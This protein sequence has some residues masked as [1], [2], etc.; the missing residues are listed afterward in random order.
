M[1]SKLL[2]LGGGGHCKSVIDTIM[3]LDAYCDIGIIDIKNHLNETVSGINIIGTDDDIPSLHNKGYTHAFITLGSIGNPQ[4]RIE[5]FNIIKEAGFE[6][7]V[8]IDK[9][10]NVSKTAIVNEGVFIGKNAIINAEAVIKKGAIINSGAIIEHD[11]TIS[12]FVHIAPGAVLGGDVIIGQN[13][14]IGTNTTIKQQVRIGR[15]CIIGMGSVVCKDIKDCILAYGNP[16]RE[17]RK[18]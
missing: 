2:L 16:C 17:V 12:D 13:T 11:C 6:I 18:I 10:A 14:H 5:L 8:I 4:R 1:I 9:T 3:G 15:D 7:P